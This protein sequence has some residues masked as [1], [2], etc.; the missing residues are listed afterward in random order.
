MENIAKS[1]LDENK[2]DINPVNIEDEFIKEKNLFS[3]L[4]LFGRKNLKSI[5]TFYPG[6]KYSKIFI[7]FL[8]IF[9]DYNNCN[10]EIKK[11]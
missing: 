8:K 7:K 3:L 4:A 10:N 2:N 6:L 1:N 5:L 11:L 9:E